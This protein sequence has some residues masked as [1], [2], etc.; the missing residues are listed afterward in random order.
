MNKQDKLRALP[1]IDE[2]AMALEDISA[3]YGRVLV[4]ECAREEIQALRAALLAG[5]DRAVDKESVLA[6]VRSRVRAETS[7]SLRPVINATGVVLHTNL[8]RA[9]LSE[10]AAYEAY[11]VARSYNTLEYD[12]ENGERGSRYSHVEGLIK[13]LTGCEAALVVNNNAA[14]VLLILSAM[15]KGREVVVSRGELV[16]IGGS[17]RVPEIMEQSGGTLRE[18]GATNKTHL[19]D[20]ERAVNENTAALLKVHT[21]NFRIIG[22]TEEV[23]LTDMCRLGREKGVPVIYD[24]GSGLMSDLQV[25]REEPKV[26]D[27]VR[28]GVDVLC[29][30]GDKLLGGPQAGIITGK[31][32]YIEKMRKHPLTRAFRVDKMTLAALEVTLR[33]YLYPTKTASIPTVEMLSATGDILS[34]RARELRLILKRI[35][36]VEATVT[37]D[38]SEVGGGSVPGQLIKTAAVVLAVEGLSPAGLE[39]ALRLS[40]T[41]VIT[42]ISHDRVI[43]DMRTVFDHQLE[44]IGEAVRLIARGKEQ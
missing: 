16:E 27:C 39:R 8:G 7:P 13:R 25:A 14:A 9:V 36:G 19:Y 23:S 15:A 29:F 11:R 44:E 4:T 35:Q 30:S 2:L 3:A 43:L 31:K 32:E 26:L 41:P 10:E 22:F 24:L 20:Y 34:G 28:A 12:V 5:E 1:K 17:F 33:Q 40:D 42:R 38:F 37:A 18:V 6:A 21:S